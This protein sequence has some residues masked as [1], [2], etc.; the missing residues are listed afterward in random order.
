MPSKARRLTLLRLQND[1]RPLPHLKVFLRV[2]AALQ[3]S[4]F[5]IRART[6]SVA[7]WTLTILNAASIR[8]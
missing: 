6:S 2:D 4:K 5:S 8:S 7:P 3:T 1:P